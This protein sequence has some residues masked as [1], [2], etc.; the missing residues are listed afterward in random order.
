MTEEFKVGDVV[1]IKSGGPSMTVVTGGSNM[2]D[3]IWFS[4]INQNY[5]YLTISIKCLEVSNADETAPKAY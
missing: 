5:F 3:L 4:K 2:I 1:R